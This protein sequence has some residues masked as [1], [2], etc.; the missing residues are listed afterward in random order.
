LRVNPDAVLVATTRIEI[1][2]SDRTPLSDDLASEV[3]FAIAHTAQARQVTG[4]QI[5]FDATRSQRSFYKAILRELRGTLPAR[6]P[7][8]ITALASWCVCGRTIP[9]VMDPTRPTARRRLISIPLTA[10]HSPTA[11]SASSVRGSGAATW[12]RPAA[13]A[14]SIAVNRWKY[15]CT[16]QS[17]LPRIAFQLL[18]RQLP[19][20]EWA[21][22]TKYWYQ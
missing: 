19:D 17:D 18:H 15:T 4:V 22:R 20:T 5:D 3:A 1:P 2:T 16:D 6:V 13:E 21:K 10:T 12:Y 11:I 7:I 9:P 8:S 14:L